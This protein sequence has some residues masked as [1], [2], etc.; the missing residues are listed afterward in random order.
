MNRVVLVCWT[1]MSLLLMGCSSESAESKREGMV[2]ALH[3]R[4][5]LN[6]VQY[7]L[8]KILTHEDFSTLEGTLL[9]EKFSVQIPGDRMIALPVDVVVKA[10]VDLS[11]LSN[12]DVEVDGESIVLYLPDPQLE[13][14]SSSID[15]THE[16]QFLSWNRSQYSEKEKEAILAAGVKK[17][18]GEMNRSDVMERARVSAHKALQ[19]MLAVAGYAP[20]QVTLRFYSE[21]SGEAS[22]KNGSVL[23]K[24][25]SKERL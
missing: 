14:T 15:Y 13:I 24:R 4:S 10:S 1:F 21:R 16:K 7:N 8:H 19:P 20:E 3:N 17:I 11:A 12:E 18:M 6:V 22:R 23:D 25:Q 9:G 2:E 5:R